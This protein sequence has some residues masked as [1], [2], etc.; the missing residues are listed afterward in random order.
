[1][2]LIDTLRG[3]G[4]KI[5]RLRPNI[6][7]EEATKN[8]LVLPFLNALGYDIFDPM[9]V[10]PEFTADISQMGT[11][12]GEK[13]DFAIVRDGK[14]IMLIEC[15]KIGANLD[16]DHASQLFRYY[17][18]TSAKI[19]ILTNGDTYRFFSE[20]EEPNKMDSK[21]FFECTMSDVS[22]SDAVEIKRFS[23]QLFDINVIAAAA[24]E[25]KYTT[26]VKAILAEEFT[27]PSD[28]FVRF[29]A[30]KSYSGMVN[31]R[32]I[33][34]FSAILRRAIPEYINEKIT[35]RLKTAMAL[36]SVTIETA[37]VETPI[38]ATE[39][40]KKTFVTTAEEYEAYYSIKAILNSGGFDGKRAVLK[41]QQ[42][43][44][45]V[46]LDNKSTTPIC[47]FYFNNPKNKQIELFHNGKN[48]PEKFAIQTLD[49]IFPLAD[50]IVMSAKQ[51]EA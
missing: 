2:D 51:Y 35:D 4:Q 8:S 10:V 41:D 5:E 43:L 33:D 25:L 20:L 14:P 32:V 27:K 21:P 39:Q 3:L 38:V 30:K 26:S 42:T 31:Q 16:N 37:T 49:D 9:E 22:E 23:K 40:E 36:S 48:S 47:K 13:V 24:L 6:Q 29:F 28:D 34:Q 19:G 17:H 46:L 44:C 45:L 50:K 18:T 1:M 11:K 15:K 12:K 7:T